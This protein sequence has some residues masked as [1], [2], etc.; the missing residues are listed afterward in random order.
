MRDQRPDWRQIVRSRLGPDAVE[1]DALE[2]V[3][4]HAEELYRSSIAEGREPLDAQT[5]V[6]AELVDI[7][8][9]M[10]EARAARRRRL[11]TGPEPVPSGPLN[12]LS[13]LVRDFAYGARLLIARPAFT[14][15]AVITLA[16]G[17]GANTAIFSIVNVLFLKPLPFPQAERLVMTWETDARDPEDVSIVS[18]PNWTDWQ[19]Q[20]TSFA[21]MAIWENLRF[22]LSGDAEPEQVFGMRASSGLFPMLGLLPQLGRTFTPAED[23]PGHDVVVIGDALWRQ[24]YG[25]APDV[26]GKVTRVNGKPHEII[27]V[28]PPAFIF[29]Q[30]R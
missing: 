17:I 30:Q 2:E 24:R 10:R 6:E 29:E 28:M 26:I 8:A 15:I 9:L 11:A 27:G 20:S 12:P 22:N 14:A 4:E 21:D 3:V 25:G 5:I 23:A 16:L 18:A 1:E 19:R 13:T 7:P